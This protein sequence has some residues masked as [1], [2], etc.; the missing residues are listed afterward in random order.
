MSSILTDIKKQLGI[1][2][3]YTAFDPDIILLIN[4][5]LPTVRQLGVFDT[6][7]AITGQTET[8]NDLLGNKDDIEEI[9]T[10]VYL[11][12]KLIFDP[13]TNS[14]VLESYK[15]FCK[16]FEWRMNIEVETIRE[17]VPPNA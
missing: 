10:Y 12:V 14:T 9:K 5:V 15:E 6:P 2:E 8:W 1:E 3:D 11:K 17:E 16:E 13:P 7:F 4:G